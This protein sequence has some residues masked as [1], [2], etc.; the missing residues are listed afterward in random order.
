MENNLQPQPEI[1][2]D[3]SPLQDNV[4]QRE[5]TKPNVQGVVDSSPIEEPTFNPPSFEDLEAQFSQQSVETSAPEP[6]SANPYVN[7]LDSKD[8][9]QASKA[10]VEAVID[11]YTGAISGDFWRFLA[12]SGDFTRSHAMPRDASS[13]HAERRVRFSRYIS[14]PVFVEKKFLRSSMSPARGWHI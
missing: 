3:F 12:I 1:I 10:L 6:E 7:N 5:Y 13:C 14:Y 4:Q 9:K 2:D 11:G 8:Q